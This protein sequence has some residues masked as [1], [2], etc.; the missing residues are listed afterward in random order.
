MSVAVHKWCCIVLSDLEYADKVYI[1][2]SSIFLCKES[3][4][5]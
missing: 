2:S 1:E 5:M 3:K 4:L